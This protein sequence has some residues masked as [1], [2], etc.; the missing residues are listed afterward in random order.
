MRGLPGSTCK[1]NG[2]VGNSGHSATAREVKTICN[3]VAAT[4]REQCTLFYGDLSRKDL[5][6]LSHHRTQ[7]AAF[8]NASGAGCGPVQNIKHLQ[9]LLWRTLQLHKERWQFFLFKTL[10]Q[11][12]CRTSKRQ[13]QVVRG[14]GLESGLQCSPGRHLYRKTCPSFKEEETP[15]RGK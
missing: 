7:K 11:E 13:I 9:C 12:L 4:Y 3:R 1:K 10:S 14:Q 15:D 6:S 8:K 5:Y 2:E